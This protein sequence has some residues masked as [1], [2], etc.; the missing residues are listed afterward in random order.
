MDRINLLMSMDKTAEA[1][2]EMK[3]LV[4]TAYV[5]AEVKEQAAG[6]LEDFDK[7]DAGGK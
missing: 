4:A 6:Y 5:P 1:V 2:K 3:V 7:P